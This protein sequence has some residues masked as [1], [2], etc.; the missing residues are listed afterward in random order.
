MQ[1]TML[2]MDLF[3]AGCAIY[4]AYTW[5]RL[6]KERKL[7]KN[8]LVLPKDKSAADCLDEEGYIRYMLPRLGV[9]TLMLI[10]YAVANVVNDMGQTEWL[11]YPWNFVPLGLVLVAL[12]WYAIDNAKAMR[13]YF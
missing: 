11:P 2:L 1:D 10:V 4:C 6:A 8:S 9:L 3:A 5:A 7:F 12:V 13:K